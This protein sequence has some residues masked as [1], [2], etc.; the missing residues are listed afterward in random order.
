MNSFSGIMV[1]DFITRDK[2]MPVYTP[3]VWDDFEAVVKPADI[4][5]F[6][7]TRRY[8]YGDYLKQRLTIKNNTNQ[9]RDLT[10]NWM[11][12]WVTDKEHLEEQ[13]GGTRT[14]PANGEMSTILDDVYLAKAGQY[15]FKMRLGKQPRD[16]E[17]VNFTV[18]DRDIEM[19]KRQGT[20][21][22][23]VITAV[24]TFL[25]TYFFSCPP[26]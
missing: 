1:G 16:T 9:D 4:R 24:V 2:R 12:Y 15:R 13:G 26:A 18:L 25:L 22:A 20:I 17:M 19:A 6:I 3:N 14:I 23:V 7:S 8:L 11:L 10:Y 21:I 5:R